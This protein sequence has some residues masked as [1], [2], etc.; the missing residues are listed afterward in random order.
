MGQMSSKLNIAVHL[1]PHDIHF[2]QDTPV[3]LIQQLIFSGIAWS[4]TITMIRYDDRRMGWGWEGLV[5][6]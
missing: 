1:R 4:S 2:Q 6:R 5:L 3:F